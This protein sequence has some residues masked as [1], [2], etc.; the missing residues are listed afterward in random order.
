VKNTKG[1]KRYAV[2]LLPA[3]PTAWRRG[4][5][6][7]LGARGGAKIDLTW[8][9]GKLKEAVV[10][11]AP[12]GDF[13]VCTDTPLTVRHGDEIV[14]SRYEN[15]VFSFKTVNDREYTITMSNE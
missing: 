14:K 8:E 7:G 3:L 6:T 9:N 15:G 5:A 10:R 2:K 12:A 1:E 11:D 13:M 4:R